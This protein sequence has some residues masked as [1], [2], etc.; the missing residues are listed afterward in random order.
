KTRKLESVGL[1]AGGI[2]HDF[3]NIL[4]AILGNISLA[5]QYAAPESTL[6]K[7]LGAAENA[8]QRATDLPQQLLTFSKG[9]AP[10]KRPMSIAEL[11][12][13]SAN[14]A[15]RGSNVRC[16]FAIPD[17]LWAV[18]VDE[19]Q[20]SQV[21]SNII[22]NADQARPYG[23]I[24]RVPAENA[25]VQAEHPVPLRPGKYVRISIKDH[26]VGIPQEH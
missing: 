21:I 4:T 8:C 10:I 11:I 12:Q 18:D 14:F 9:G 3:N 1:L 13:E 22:I 23:G 5:K 24:I 17:T 2:A 15:L 7:R 16:E 6:L 20:M 19:G 25:T 26:G